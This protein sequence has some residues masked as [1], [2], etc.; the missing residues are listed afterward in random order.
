MNDRAHADPAIFSDPYLILYVLP[1]IQHKMIGADDPDVWRNLR[2]VI[3]IDLP[4]RL[5]IASR[6]Y[7]RRSIDADID[8]VGKPYGRSEMY[9]PVAVPVKAQQLL[10][11]P[12]TES[13]GAFI[14]PGI[15]DRPQKWQRF[16]CPQKDAALEYE[17]IYAAE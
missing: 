4:N 16:G 8:I 12:D 3:Y 2:I 15:I 7:P 9:R 13:D 14:S 17:T 5:N 10:K 1:D 6:R 11:K